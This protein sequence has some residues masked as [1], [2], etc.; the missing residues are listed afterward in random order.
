MIRAA[1]NSSFG[2]G[3]W[4]NSI[5]QLIEDVMWVSDTHEKLL[6]VNRR[7]L[8][9]LHRNES[10]VIGKSLQQLNDIPNDHVVKQFTSNI[11]SSEIIFEGWVTFLYDEH[12]EYIEWHSN[13]LYNERNERIGTVFAG[14]NVT[15][16]VMAEQ[17]IQAQIAS[18]KEINFYQSHVIRKPLANVLGLLKLIPLDQQCDE[19]SEILNMIYAS[20]Q[21]LDEVIHAVVDRTADN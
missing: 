14:K 13:P 15:N 16:R 8:Q 12:K 11:S 19:V 21:E 3:N 17:K 5:F 2:T 9:L 18:L 6:F 20:A 4:F 1:N 7:F 10:E